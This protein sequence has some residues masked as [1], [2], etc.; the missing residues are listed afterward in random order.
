MGF[1]DAVEKGQSSGKPIASAKMT[2]QKAVELGEYNPDFLSTFP[3][4]H[5]LSRHVQFQFIRQALDNRHRHLIVQW[6]EINNLLDFSKKP[7]LKEALKNIEKQLNELEKDKE[8]LY[9]EYS[10]V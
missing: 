6:A 4:W 3:E 10:K 7:E 8:K 2:L 5:T 1:E 9:L